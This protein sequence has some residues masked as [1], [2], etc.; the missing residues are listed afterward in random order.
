MKALYIDIRILAH[1]HECQF[2]FWKNHHPES[3][4]RGHWHC[5]LFDESCQFNF[6]L[7]DYTDKRKVEPCGACRVLVDRYERL[8][9]V[10]PQ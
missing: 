7:H 4:S 2:I 5:A 9:E 3:F 6:P 10:D 8:P 1:C